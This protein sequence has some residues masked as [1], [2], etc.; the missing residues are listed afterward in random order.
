M[1]GHYTKCNMKP[2]QKWKCEGKDADAEG[3]LNQWLF[4]VTGSGVGVSGP[5]LKSKS[6]ELAERLGH[7]SF[8]PTD[9]WLS[10]FKCRFGTKF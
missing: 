9:A 4:I 3:A 2:P 5:V 7:N 1:N 8:K 10:Q 6:E